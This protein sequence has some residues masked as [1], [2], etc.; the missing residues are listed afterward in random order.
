MN[1]RIQKMR[2][3]FVLEKGQRAFWQPAEDPYV[4]ADSYEKDG[5]SDIDRSTERLL[6]VLNKEKLLKKRLLKR[7]ILLKMFSLKK[8]K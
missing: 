2:D 4:L 6:Y 1:D 7:K 8:Q 5:L 3:F